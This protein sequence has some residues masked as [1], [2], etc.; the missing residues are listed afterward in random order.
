MF[1][2]KCGNSLPDGALFCSS[3]GNPVNT[4]PIMAANEEPVVTAIEEPVV[5]PIEEPVMA[6]T[7]TPTQP[8]YNMNMPVTQAEPKNKSKAPLFIGLGIGGLLITIIALVLILVLGGDDDNKKTPALATE[9]TSTEKNKETESTT[10]KSN[11]KEPTTKEPATEESTTSSSSSKVNLKDAKRL[12]TDIMTDFKNADFKSFGDY[13]I[14]G[15][16]TYIEDN[17]LTIDSFG[18][19]M[20]LVF[21]DNTL[22]SF[23]K[24]RVNDAVECDDTFFKSEGVDKQLRA[25]P[26]YKKPT[27]FAKVE[28]E[29]SYE[30][31]TSSIDLHFAYVDGKCYFYSYDDSNFDLEFED[32]DE[33]DSTDNLLGGDSADVVPDMLAT[34]FKSVNDPSFTGKVYQ[35]DGFQMTV[36]ADWTENASSSAVVYTAQG[37]STNFNIL[38]VDTLGLYTGQELVEM[39]YDTYSTMGCTDI[40]VGNLSTTYTTGYYIEYKYLGL[41]GVQFLYP[42]TDNTKVYI[43]TIT[44]PDLNSDYYDTAESAAASFKFN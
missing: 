5:A 32:D 14:P 31:E 13:L 43:I 9:N 18:T 36:P 3:C 29:I 19:L 20:S 2:S 44:T 28:I 11:T 21:Y 17:D 42:D 10:N 15:M 30:G 41:N 38:S 4:Q 6:A 8:T 39:Y 40:K 33:S 35:G 22:T 26:E 12:A 7:F 1:C 37:D 25:Y 34:N 16:A 24:Y 23:L 27:A